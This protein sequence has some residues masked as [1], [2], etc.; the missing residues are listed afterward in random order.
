MTNHGIIKCQTAIS[1]MLNVENAEDYSGCLCLYQLAI[2]LT[3]TRPRRRERK[4]MTDYPIYCKECVFWH[5]SP[6]DSRTGHC[7]R[8]APKDMLDLKV[9]FHPR[10]IQKHW[11]GDGRMLVKVDENTGIQNYLHGPQNPPAQGEK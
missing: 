1:L 6:N 3:Q 11:C 8:H 5:E 10:T 4:K 2:L 7:R 9:A